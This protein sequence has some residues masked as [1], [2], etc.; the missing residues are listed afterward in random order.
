LPVIEELALEF[1]GR[2]RFVRVDVAPGG[3]VLERFG[4]SGLPAYLL[5]RDGVEVDRMRLGFLDWFL[6]SRLRRMVNGA[7]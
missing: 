3:G 1:A 4:A 7:L 5:F 2:A 6:K